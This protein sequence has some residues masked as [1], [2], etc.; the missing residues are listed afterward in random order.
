MSAIM[1]KTVVVVLSIII[2]GPNALG[3][4]TISNLL[5]TGGFENVSASPIT[6]LS[7]NLGAWFVEKD[8]LAESFGVTLYDIDGAGP[9]GTSQA[10]WAKAGGASGGSVILSQDVDLLEGL[11]YE[12]S[13]DIAS[14][15]IS[16]TNADGGLMTVAW[17]GGEQLARYNFDI[18]STSS[19][20]Y[21]TLSGTYLAGESGVS[22]LTIEMYRRYQVSRLSPLN[23]V[24]NVHLGIVPAPGAIFLGCIGVGIVSWLRKRRI[25]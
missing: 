16:G 18:I 12:F 10:F 5:G 3:N 20:G 22:T 13:V 1:K 21:A 17:L 25:F 14:Q 11:L 24:D 7:S 19:P 8:S 2:L 4:P 6:P 15:S 23:Y 9:L